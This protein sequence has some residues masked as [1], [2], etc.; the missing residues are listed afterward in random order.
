VILARAVPTAFYIHSRLK[1]L[2]GQPAIK[3][4]T[5]TINILFWLITVGLAV[6]RLLPLTAIVAVGILTLRAV[7]GLRKHAQV[8][9][10]KQI[11]MKEFAY[12][13]QMVVLIALGYWFHL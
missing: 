2:K 6:Y 3:K 5:L 1:I 8:Q 13:I 7:N 12:G 11:G 10:V 4:T 9:T